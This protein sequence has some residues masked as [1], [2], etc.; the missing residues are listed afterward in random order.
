M[1][2]RLNLKNVHD[3]G[4]GHQPTGERV[5]TLSRCNRHGVRTTVASGWRVHAA[6]V[7]NW[8]RRVAV[9]ARWAVGARAG[10]VDNMTG[11]VNGSVPV[12]GKKNDFGL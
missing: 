2:G 9:A 3:R 6:A 1:S 8:G 10:R 11:R 4:G 5:A 7:E 12:R